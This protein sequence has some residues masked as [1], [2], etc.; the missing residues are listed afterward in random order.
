MKKLL[1]MTLLFF[2]VVAANAQ[3]VKVSFGVKGVGLGTLPKTEIAP[4]TM[5]QFGGGGG[6]FVGARLWN[7]LGLQV[8]AL[9]GFQT[10]QYNTTSFGEQ[11][12]V[13]NQSHL[14]VPIILQGWAGRSFAVEFGYQQAIA[15][16]GSL[17][18][19]KTTKPDTGILDY[20]SILAGININMGK[21]AFLNLRY[22]LAVQNSYVMTTQPSKNMGF[23]VGLGFRFYNSK[24][25]VF[26]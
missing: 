14:F 23:Q 12:W 8:E 2:S 24:K 17:T 10:A 9:Y 6:A 3:I 11:T 25:S 20:G 15:L 5:V 16:S 22:T 4:T 26:E 1:V 7:Y 13:S 18:D 19:G 21:V